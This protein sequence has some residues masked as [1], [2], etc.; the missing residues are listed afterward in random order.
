MMCVVELR[1]VPMQ[2]DPGQ[3]GILK[4][5]LFSLMFHVLYAQ[6]ISDPH[7]GIVVTH[8]KDPD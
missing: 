6:I 1:P 5:S 4:M 8:Y 7:M 2:I 3:L